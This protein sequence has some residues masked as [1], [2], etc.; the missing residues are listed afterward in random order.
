[1][2]RLP[3]LPAPAQ[4]RLRKD[5]AHFHPGNRARTERG[6]QGNVESPIRRQQ[7][8]IQPVFFQPF[9]MA[10]KHRNPRPVLAL[11]KDL[12]RLISTRIKRHF[13]LLLQR[14]FARRHIKMINLPRRREPRQEIMRRRVLLL[15]AESRYIAKPRQ[16]QLLHHLPVLL[17]NR[18][19]IM[20]IHQ[21]R[22]HKPPAQIRHLAQQ[23]RLLRQDRPPVLRR[24][25]RQVHRHQPAVRRILRRDH[26][27]DRPIVSHH[28]ILGIEIFKQLHNRPLRPRRQV[29]VKQPILRSRPLGNMNQQIPPII[30]LPSPQTP[31]RLVRTLIQQPILLLR[32]PH[33][34]HIHLLI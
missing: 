24:R 20:R 15:P 31:F 26:I 10:E 25:M 33:F 17:M 29:P 11:E 14:A 23:T 16:L 6:R 19:L 32:L 34:V 3:I 28:R 27:P 22:H 2:P 5:P 12:L 1:M 8:R 9:L 4:I 21:P 18:D 7:R 30:R 13:R